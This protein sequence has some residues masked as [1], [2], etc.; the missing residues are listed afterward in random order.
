MVTRVQK[1]GN[2]QGLRVSKDVLEKVHITIGDMVD[3][4]VEK[5]GIFI[6][7]VRQL[8]GKYSLREL[9]RQMPK[10]YKPSLEVWSEPSGKEVW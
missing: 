10:N 4:R 7:P 8:R 5:G 9:V 1:W 3:V 2:S 6:Q